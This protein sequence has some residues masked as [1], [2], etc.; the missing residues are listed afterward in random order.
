M[1]DFGL[2]KN[3]QEELVKTLEKRKQSEGEYV[4]K[5]FCKA[6]IR[7][8]RLEISEVMLRIERKCVYSGLLGKEK[9]Q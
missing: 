8:L 2:L 3:L 6:K 9:W 5:E 4:R 1:S 7:R